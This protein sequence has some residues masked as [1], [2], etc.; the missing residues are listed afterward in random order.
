MKNLE[1]LEISALNQAPKSFLCL[2]QVYFT[3]RV[4]LACYLKGRYRT[5]TFGR[6]FG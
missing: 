2:V 3:L 6:A 5:V 1:A 4:Y